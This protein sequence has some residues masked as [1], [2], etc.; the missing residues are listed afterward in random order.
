MYYTPLEMGIS[1]E[2]SCDTCASFLAGSLFLLRSSIYNAILVLMYIL[3]SCGE[4]DVLSEGLVVT[5]SW[6]DTYRA[7]LKTWQYTHVM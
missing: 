7:L 5:S 3:V 6:P 2:M 4:P 1:I